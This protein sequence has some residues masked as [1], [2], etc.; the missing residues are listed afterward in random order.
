MTKSS[1]TN[2]QPIIDPQYVADWE[3]LSDSVQESRHAKDFP[4]INAR[5]LEKIREHE[6]R[7]LANAL[8]LWLAENH[9]IAR[10]WKSV[11]QA[12]KQAISLVNADEFAEI[13]TVEAVLNSQAAAYEIGPFSIDRAVD[14]RQQHIE[15]LDSVGQSSFVSRY[16]GAYF[17]ED[18]A[19]LSDAK[20]ILKE[21]VATGESS[22]LVGDP[23]ADLEFLETHPRGWANEKQLCRTLL[24]AMQQRNREKL[25]AL[26]CV[27]QFA[28][29]I[30]GGHFSSDNKEANLERLLDELANSNV[31]PDSPLIEGTANKRY[32]HTKGW[33]GEYFRHKVSFRLERRL[34]EWRW[35]GILLMTP[36][37]AWAS[38][39]P[40]IEPMTNQPLEMLIRAPWPAGERFM[41][42]GVTQFIRNSTL[43]A[44]LTGAWFGLGLLAAGIIETALASRRCGYGPRGFYYNSALS[45]THRN[46]NAFA[47]DFT[48]Y[49]VGLSYL[50][51]SGGTPVLAI[52]MGVVESLQ[53]GGRSG[54]GTLNFVQI[55]HA[56]GFFATGGPGTPTTGAT[57]IPVFNPYRS[58]YLH[59]AGRNMLNVTAMM[60]V[61]QGSRLGL[62]NDTGRNSALDH[63]HLVIHD[64]RL[65][66]PLSAMGRSVRITPIDGRQTLNDD[67]EGSCIRSSNLPFPR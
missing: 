38:Q 17:L 31:K 58:R 59:L 32:F 21:L 26:A 48:K 67:Q 4:K 28:I 35:T 62:I 10:D 23:V 64:D 3:R 30:G 50:N 14:A 63:L 9:R 12:Y 13:D 8:P 24:A 36:T 40:P 45:G 15:H 54:F 43:I 51:T 46:L 11:P 18:S 41:A 7:P 66:T 60:P 29:G 5:L 16:T 6:S 53:G 65:L 25:S 56:S 37:R 52:Q 2:D 42:G 1:D 47:V 39:F 22:D 19:Q 33:R 34:G 49:A 55:R 20:Q 57:P 44:V 27:S 61:R